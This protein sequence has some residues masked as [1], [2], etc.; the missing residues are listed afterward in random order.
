MNINITYDY[1][2]SY[3][4]YEDYNEPYA[5]VKVCHCEQCRGVRDKRKNRVLKK[6]V[7]RVYNKKRRNCKHNGKIIYYYWA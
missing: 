1:T 4:E 3:E 2:E 5:I 7:K 6:R